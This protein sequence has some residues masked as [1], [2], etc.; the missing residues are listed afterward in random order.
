[1]NIRIIPRTK[2]WKFYL[3]LKISKHNFKIGFYYKGDEVLFSLNPIKWI[4]G[5][6][7]FSISFCA[8]FPTLK[9]LDK[10]WDEYFEAITKSYKESLEKGSKNE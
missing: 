1:M 2:W 8:Y 5:K 10:L 6:A 7:F 3:Y 9:A 4:Q